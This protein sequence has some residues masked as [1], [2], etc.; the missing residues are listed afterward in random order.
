MIYRNSKLL[1]IQQMYMQMTLWFMHEAV[2]F[3]KNN[4]KAKKYER[5]NDKVQNVSFENRYWQ[6][7]SHAY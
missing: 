1:G 3:L 2:I 6:I 4:K 7:L 5:Y